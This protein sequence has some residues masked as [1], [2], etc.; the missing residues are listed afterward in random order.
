MAERQGVEI[1]YYPKCGGIWLDRG[2]LDKIVERSEA[3]SPQ[4]SFVQPRS[5][6]APQPNYP[7]RTTTAATTTMTMITGRTTPPARSESPSSEIY[8]ISATDCADQARKQS[9]STYARPHTQDQRA[10]GKPSSPLWQCIDVPML[11]APMRGE[12]NCLMDQAA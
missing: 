10:G 9:P 2:E 8:S 7:N 11:A 6:A 4:P 12:I 5:G 3:A 1:D